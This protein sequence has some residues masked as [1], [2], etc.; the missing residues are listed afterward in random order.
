MGLV[1]M[2]P[3]MWL[4][5]ELI[6]HRCHVQLAAVRQFPRGMHGVALLLQWPP[7]FTLELG[8][9]LLV[10]P[11]CHGWVGWVIKIFQISVFSKGAASVQPAALKVTLEPPQCVPHACR[12]VETLYCL[13]PRVDSASKPQWGSILLLVRA[14]APCSTPLL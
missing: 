9:A 13:R 4:E 5:L 7:C 1:P 2:T 8:L 3:E 12:V 11:C 6:K 14:L 10:W